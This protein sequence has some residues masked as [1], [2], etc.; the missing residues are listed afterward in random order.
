MTTDTASGRDLL[1]PAERAKLKTYH[2]PLTVLLV[3]VAMALGAIG[4]MSLSQATLGV[5][6]LAAACLSAILGRIA[7]AHSQHR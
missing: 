6:L 4:V 7:Q 1:A 5:G 2:S 3:I